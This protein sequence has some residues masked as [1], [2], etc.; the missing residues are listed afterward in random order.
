MTQADQESQK[1][2]GEGAEAPDAPARM[3]IAK[4][5]AR[6]GL[7]SRRD[8]E[9]L[10]EEGRVAVNG[11]VLAT[12]ACVVTEKDKVTV[13]GKALPEA[14]TP[15]LWRYHKPKGLVTSH[16]D[17]QGR[18]T[19]FEA[20]PPELPRVISIGRLDIATEGLLLLTTDG[21]IARHLELPSTGWLRRYRVRAYGQVSDEQLEEIRAGVT[22]DG[23]AY[24]PVEASIE[25]VQG[26]NIWL[27]IGIREGKNRE[28]KRLLE[29][30]GLKVNRLIR[31]SF[32]PFQ[33]GELAPGAI[34]EVGAKAL[35]SHLGVKLAQEL[36]LRAPTKEGGK[37]PTPG[38]QGKPHSPRGPQN[39]RKAK[40]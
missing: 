8:A 40:R 29:H 12:P 14:E 17:E 10:I 32:G 21:A 35:V 24:G 38:K 23:I 31:I 5:I 34:Q 36:G 13:D 3:R 30:L 27:A 22:I 15:R 16:K 20:L 19:V 1:Q 9:K 37:R 4:L 28:V 33:L 7:C 11:K 2:Q 39:R 26:G 25:R 18:K 6:A